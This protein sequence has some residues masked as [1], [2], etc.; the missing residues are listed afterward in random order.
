VLHGRAGR[1][2]RP[3]IRRTDVTG[4]TARRIGG[5]ALLAAALACVWALFAP[6]Q[7][8][9]STRYVILD[10]TSM[11]PSLHGG[12]LALVRSRKDVAR[13]DV[14]L[15]EH[16]KLGAHVL[17]RIVRIKG[18]R[19]VLKGDNNDFLDDVRPT[20]ADVEGRLWFTVPKVGHA[21]GWGRQPLHAAL[22]VFALAFLALGGAAAVSAARSPARPRGGS[23]VRIAE[24][25]GDGGGDVAR[26]A[27]TA[28]LAGLVIFAGLALV[29]HSRSPTRASTVE[30]AYEHVGTFSYSAVVGASDVYPDGTVDSGE[31]VF[32]QLVPELDIAFD[33]R[34]A[35]D[36]ARSVRGEAGL[37]AVLSDGA[38]WTRQIPAGD[39]VSF[40][41]PTARVAGTL[42]LA[43][44]T[45]IV[46]EMK[47]L[48]G[49]GTSTFSLD[50]VPT[51][52]LV[53]VVRD[54]R[55]SQSFSPQLPLLVDTV[56]LRP[57]ASSGDV[58]AFSVRRGEVMT[59]RV[60]ADLH[61]GGLV[62]SVEIARRVSLLGLG[63]AI[64]CALVAGF[65]YRRSRGA[66]ESSR[67][68]SL[69][70][71]RMVSIAGP[72]AGSSARATELADP[73][74]LSRIAE[75]YDRVVLHWREGRVHVYQV[76]DGSTVYRYRAGL[77]LEPTRPTAVEDEDTLVL[78]GS[79]RT[80]RAAEG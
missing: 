80:A 33:Y 2:L 24:A 23:R 79:K 28:A 62:L 71:D 66:G 12:D 49:S 37:A 35:A 63:V 27:L 25:R 73:E 69:F 21:I 19:L 4:R 45:A 9:G 58:A 13:G 47:T 17:H 26:V 55:V 42:D 48:T 34:L 7:L 53:G 15:Y 18:D 70:R 29:S 41:G 65:A 56:S 75:H 64:L 6:P 67:I 59:A 68:D 1:L 51:V 31:A 77:D 74:S 30:G 36:D 39:P 16:E 57:D 38:G 11:E 43:G 10:G 22:I 44:L 52:E 46:E 14:V 3:A 5:L 8:G 60:P 50:I 61:L 54:T 40:T 32:L 20:A 78:G 76:D 72:P